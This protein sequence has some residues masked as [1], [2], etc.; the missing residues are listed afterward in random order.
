MHTVRA[1]SQTPTYDQLRG[2]RINADVPPSEVDPTRLEQPGRHHPLDAPGLLAPGPARDAAAPQATTWSWFESV[3]GKTSGKHHFWSEVSGAT[4]V[5]DPSPASPACRSRLRMGQAENAGAASATECDESLRPSPPGLPAALPPVAH[6]R[7]TP[8]HGSGSSAIPAG[9][10]DNL[11]RDKP[12]GV[13]CGHPGPG[14]HPPTADRAA[15]A[16][17]MPKAVH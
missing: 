10:V 3:E 8:S 11:S 6:A 2:E 9:A 7:H 14:L 13:R 1:V 15:T 4:E 17:L 16:Y 12:T 5:S